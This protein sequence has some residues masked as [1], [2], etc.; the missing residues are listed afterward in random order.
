[1]KRILFVCTGNICRSPTAEGVFRARVAEA[2]LEQDFEIDSCGMIA[3]HVGERPDPRTRAL[4]RTR[5]VSLDDLRARQIKAADYRH[6][7]L[8]LAMDR[9][10]L[11]QMRAQAPADCHHKLQL[12]LAY[13]DE[14]DTDEVPDPYYGGPAG[15]DLAFDLVDRGARALLKALT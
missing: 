4:A 2:G 1:M 13:L 3:Y 15:F 8:L 11:E 12:F 14:D 5:G 7:D 10:H 6:Y 9:G